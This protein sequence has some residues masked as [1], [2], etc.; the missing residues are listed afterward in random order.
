MTLPE[1]IQRDYQD[2]I[3]RL[4]NVLKKIIPEISDLQVHVIN[5]E[6]KAIVRQTVINIGNHTTRLTS[7]ITHE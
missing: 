3:D 4:T 5:N 7:N 1:E 6:V 2:G